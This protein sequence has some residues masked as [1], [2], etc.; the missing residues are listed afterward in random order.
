MFVTQLTT[1]LKSPDGKSYSVPLGR[2]T[3]LLGENESNKSAVAEALMLARTG[4][5]VGLPYKDK[6][7]KSGEYLIALIPPASDKLTVRTVTNT[8][9]GAAFDYERGS[10]PSRT[11][12]NNAVLAL[13][14]LREKMGAS[15]EVRARFFYKYL[16]PPQRP[17]VQ[18]KLTADML[19]FVEEL[20]LNTGDLDAALTALDAQLKLVK[21]SL[22]T[23]T[24]LQALPG[25]VATVSEQALAE[26]EEDY[27]AACAVALIR[28]VAQGVPVDAVQALVEAA[29]GNGKL[30]EAPSLD[31]AKGALGQKLTDRRLSTALKTAGATQT[32]AGLKRERLS[33][34]RKVLVGQMFEDLKEPLA[35]LAVRASRF[36]PQGESF[37]FYVVGT[38]LQAFL[39]RG[40]EE[41]RALSGST[42]QRFLTAL[43]CAFAQEGDLIVMADRAFDPKTL[44]GTLRSLTKAPC[45]VIV[46]SPVRPKGRKPSGWAFVELAREDGQPLKVS[47]L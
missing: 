21:Q 19:A 12:P 10:R 29:G 28:K 17:P 20:K 18:D 13:A 39:K 34:L 9:E 8:N 35:A 46:T 2:L 16:K 14:G 32:R 40:D 15:N 23:A 6:A 30:R 22:A 36:L 24:M 26:A 5:V 1:N 7:M 43:A 11:G 3:L 4:S 37:V 45:Q 38:T 31:V 44:A 42:E 27:A 41:Y 47:T 33:S 25:S